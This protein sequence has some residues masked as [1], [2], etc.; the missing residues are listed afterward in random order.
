MD[1]EIFN[2]S[3]LEF[4][5]A[6]ANPFSNAGKASIQAIIE[7]ATADGVT[8]KNFSKQLQFTKGRPGTQYRNTLWFRRFE[9]FREQS[10][11]SQVCLSRINEVTVT[12]IR[13]WRNR[14][15]A[16]KLRLLRLRHASVIDLVE[17]SAISFLYEAFA[18]LLDRWI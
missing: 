6:P 5:P 10:L 17:W 3:D 13:P 8:S 11:K 14:W 7:H 2:S 1:E 12:D 9:S 18:L 4:E 15:I 16:S